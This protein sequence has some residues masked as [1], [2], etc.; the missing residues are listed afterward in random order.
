[1]NPSELAA[2]REAEQSYLGKNIA[3]KAVGLGL[4]A[5]GAYTGLK[6][7]LPLLNKSVPSALAAKGLSKIDP[8][9]GE[10]FKLLFANG[11]NIDQGM[12]YLRENVAGEKPKEEGGA[13]PQEAVNNM[14]Q[15]VQGQNQTV[16]G[17]QDP[18]QIIDQ[19]S[20]TVSD[21]LRQKITG[22][23]PPQS[24]AAI[25]KQPSSSGIDR[26]VKSIE[27]TTGKNFVDWISELFG[28]QGG[29][30]PQAPQQQINR[31]P[32]QAQSYGTGP[33]QTPPQPQGGNNQDAAIMA[34]LEKIMKM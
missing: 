15:S 22:G 12:D 25:A 31:P 9:L 26:E 14:V 4:S 2:G 32:G 34:A 8:R 3:T 30:Q 7:I 29:G 27:K 21:F 19:Y 10:F 20:P 17:G 23:Q 1:M 6:R 28:Q 18:Y 16:Q 5:A 24:A 13:P 33:G 11:Y